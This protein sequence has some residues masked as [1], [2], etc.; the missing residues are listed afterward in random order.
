[1]PL[2]PVGVGGH[3]FLLRGQQGKQRGDGLRHPAD[4]RLQP[5][6]QGAD[7]PQGKGQDNHPRREQQVG[8]EHPPGTARALHQHLLPQL[9]LVDH[10]QQQREEY[11]PQRAHQGRGLR[12]GS[13]QGEDPPAQQEYRGGDTGPVESGFPQAGR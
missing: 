13:A 6:P 10:Q 8:R 2:S 1:M 11:Q 9:A 3:G 12:G 4:G 7:V 5:G